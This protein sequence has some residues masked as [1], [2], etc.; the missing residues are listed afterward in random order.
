MYSVSN[1]PA[2]GIGGPSL[3]RASNERSSFKNKSRPKSPSLFRFF[4]R[5]HSAGGGGRKVSYDVDEEDYGAD[6]SS[7]SEHEDPFSVSVCVCV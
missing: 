6:A 2:G 3:S 5:G 4:V 1:F 7:G